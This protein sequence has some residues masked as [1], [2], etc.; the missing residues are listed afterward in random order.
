MLIQHF[1]SILHITDVQSGRLHVKK[2][3]SL[4]QIRTAAMKKK[5]TKN[6]Q[7]QK[8][9]QTKRKQVLSG[10]LTAKTVLPAAAEEQVP[11]GLQIEPASEP[12][13]RFL[14][15]MEAPPPPRRV[16]QSPAVGGACVG[17]APFGVW[18]SVALWVWSTVAP[19]PPRCHLGLGNGSPVPAAPTAVRVPTP[20]GGGGRC[21]PPTL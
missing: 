6:E 7:Q 19:P 15:I 16:H 12:Y 17:L 5:L 11:L 8:N 18:S 9:K 1:D 21:Q 14:S 20:P 10:M 13:L 2:T 4:P 3:V